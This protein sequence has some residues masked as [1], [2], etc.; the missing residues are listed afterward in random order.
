M[1]WDNALVA[2]FGIGAAEKSNGPMMIAGDTSSVVMGVNVFSQT[3]SG[4]LG[5]ALPIVPST[6]ESAT[7]AQNATVL[8]LDGL[9]YSIDSTRGTRSNLILTEFLGMPANV[10]VQLW[11]KGDRVVPISTQ[12][13]AVPANGKIQLSTVFQGDAAEKDR[14]NVRL[15]VKADPAMPGKVLAMVTT[16]DNVTGDTKNALAAPVGTSTSGSIG[17]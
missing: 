8:E 16:I 11:E 15:T 9:E 10:T 13:V 14:T 12:V 6:T 4:T 7:G 17:F 3:D 2:L 5:D 1:S